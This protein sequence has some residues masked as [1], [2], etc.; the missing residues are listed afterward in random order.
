MPASTG[1]NPILPV[2]VANP[3]RAVRKIA[4]LRAN[5]LGDY[6]FTLPALYSLRAAYPRAELTLL[7]APWHARILSGRPGPIDY[8]AVVPAVS[9]VRDGDSAPGELDAFRRWAMGEEFDIALQMHGGGKYSNPLV[10]ALGARVTAGLRAVDAAPLD[11]W[12]PYVYY[13]PEV[14]RM[15]EVVGL[16]G[17]PPVTHSPVFELTDDDRA[18][19]RALVGSPTRPR[20]VLHP[21][22]SD[23]RRRW[24]AER[25]AAVGDALAAAGVEVLVTGVGSERETVDEVCGRMRYPARPLV[26]ALTISGLAGLLADSALL[27]SNDTGPL[28]LAA[29]VGTRTVG[30]F[31]IGNMIN[32]A[33]PERGRHRALISWTI[34][35]P[36]CGLDC[37]RDI[38]PARTGGTGCRHSPSFVADIP[39]VEAE[40]EAL[41]LLNAHRQEPVLVA[42]RGR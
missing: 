15:L 20:A 35:C 33:L 7:G 13:Q 11:R 5:A 22:A 30:L 17:A 12:I 37:T 3:V 16:V 36:E 31:W 39:A 24:P 41:D 23:A 32:G 27:I 19:A 10:S 28:H 42:A 9:G 25:F 2:P 8:V 6:L 1:F 21:G 34:H 4:V 29:A 18:Q 38:Y 26:D 40:A 14:F